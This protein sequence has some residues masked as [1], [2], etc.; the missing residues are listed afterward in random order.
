MKHTISNCQFSSA[1]SR[2]ALMAEAFVPL[3]LGYYS[4]EKYFYGG[5]NLYRGIMQIRVVDTQLLS[6]QFSLFIF[7]LVEDLYNIFFY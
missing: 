5:K 3:Q 4:S 6:A 2:S 7:L 1:I